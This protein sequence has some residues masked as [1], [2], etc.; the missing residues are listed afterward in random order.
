MNFPNT[1]GVHRDR[2]SVHSLAEV[3]CWVCVCV[4]VCACCV[5]IMKETEREKTEAADRTSDKM[6][7]FILYVPIDLM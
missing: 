3:I 4:C 5:Y 7:A 6:P 1:G 2:Q